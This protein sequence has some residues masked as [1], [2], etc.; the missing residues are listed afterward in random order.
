MNPSRILTATLLAATSMVATIGCGTLN[1][2]HGSCTYGFAVMSPCSVSRDNGTQV[3]FKAAGIKKIRW[4]VR[5]GDPKA[6]SGTVDGNGLY[7]PPSYL[8]T[9]TAISYISAT[10]EA[11]PTNTVEGSVHL[12]PGFLQPLSPENA[13][14]PAGGSLKISGS[15]AQVGSGEI[16]WSLSGSSDGK[17]PL[18]ADYGVLSP[19][20]CTR[21]ADQYTSCRVTYTAPAKLPGVSTSVYIIAEAKEGAAKT[22][23]HILLNAAGINS[24]AAM[25]QAMQNGGIALGTSG[26]NNGDF[27]LFTN[28]RQEQ[29]IG[30]CCGGTLGGLIQD[31]EGHRYILSNNHVLAQSDRAAIGSLIVQPGLIDGNCTPFGE[32]A[33]N[34]RPVASLSAFVPLSESSS[35]VDAAIAKVN[36]GSVDTNG[37]I[38]QLGSVGAEGILR[39][40]PPAAGQGEAVTSSNVSSLSVIKSGRTT[41]LTC[42]SMEAIGA[43]L[44]VQYYKDCA[45]T[46]FYLTK[47]FTNQL[48]IGGN[49]FSDAGDSG[50]LVL[51]AENAQVVGLLFASGTDRRGN[52]Y[53]I[54]NPIG[55]V[56]RELGQQT[57]AASSFSIV[58]GAPHRVACLNYDTEVINLAWSQTLTARAL[59]KRREAGTAAQSLVSHSSGILGVA[60]GKSADSLGEGAIVLYVDKNK[61]VNVPAI[62]H[63]VRTVVMP[64]EAST[65]VEGTGAIYPPLTRGI[66]L[67]ASTLEA[68]LKIKQ[69]KTKEILSDAAF[70]GVGIGQSYDNPAEAAL[71]VFVDR[72]REPKETP[73]T[74]GGLRVRYIVMDRFHVTRGKNNENPARLKCAPPISNKGTAALQ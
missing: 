73:S 40:A 29:Y 63:D 45:E 59:D 17:H 21:G 15:L 16:Q 67:P 13:A 62:F 36:V 12:T 18:N 46:N 31:A 8:T 60:L 1:E 42:S 50:S 66:H 49:S 2:S 14:L 20:S 30:D 57:G 41:G 11:D 4:T 68:A 32:P 19:A 25:N 61:A 71:I 51:D 47:T 24:T 65:F 58:G 23:M 9:D 70:F 28:S 33:A 44:E 5:G 39:P 10:D 3:Q 72:K 52:G 48:V 53:G 38:L 74:I 27:D 37:G 56:L 54:A 69:E 7:T 34:I 43:T 6:G 22:Y 35:N 55:D 26:S 64:V